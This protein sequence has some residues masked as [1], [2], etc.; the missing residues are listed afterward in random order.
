[1]LS[2]QYDTRVQSDGKVDLAINNGALL[3]NQQAGN[4]Q[5]GNQQGT[6]DSETPSSPLSL[7]REYVP[8]QLDGFFELKR[9]RPLRLQKKLYEF[10]TAP[11]TKFWADSVSNHNLK[12]VPPLYFMRPFSCSWLICSS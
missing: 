9:H 4:Q 6:L 12:H 3:S 10:F 1:M 8:L 11:I 5:A 7:A 2:E